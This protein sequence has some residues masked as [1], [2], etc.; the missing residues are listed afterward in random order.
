M[1]RKRRRLKPLGILVFLIAVAWVIY[2][3]YIIVNMFLNK[4]VE[5]ASSDNGNQNEEKDPNYVKTTSKG[6]IL[7]KVDGI[8]YIDGH[9][10]VNKTYPLPL[11]FIP[12]NTNEAI[13]SETD[14]CQNCIN[15]EAWEQFVLMRSDA[16][17]L[18]LNIWNQ[19]GFRSIEYQRDLY[20]QFVDRDGQE[21]A[22]RYSARPG[23]SEHHTSLA[24]DL[25]TITQAFAAT[26]EGIWVNENAHLYGFIIRY[27]EGKESETGFMYEPWHLRF[28]GKELAM[29]L[30][31]DGA[32]LSMEG[33]FGLESVYIN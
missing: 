16:A 14:I 22:D 6:Y 17:A 19:S 2:G 1:K 11:D 32:W 29:I 28:V 18:G 21:A 4:E 30:F 13:T 12:T 31:N 24:I 15:V 26:A 9:L 20:Q 33:Y 10:I 27:P 5:P 8:Y 25:N 7:T 23:H 3:G